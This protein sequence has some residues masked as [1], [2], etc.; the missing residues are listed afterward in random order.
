VANLIGVVQSGYFLWG[1]ALG[2]LGLV[3]TW[4]VLARR[5]G[6]GPFAVG[7]AMVAVATVAAVG[8]SGEQT[9]AMW[10]GLGLIL[11]GTAAAGALGLSHPSIAASSIPGSIV[12]ALAAPANPAWVR[13]L[14]VFA[15]PLLGYFV[16]DFESRYADRGLGIVF[17]GLATMGTFLAVPDT[18]LVRALFAVC[19]PMSLT[20]WPRPLLW[21]GRSGAFLAVSIFVVFT[22]VGGIGRPASIV[23]ALACLGYL[24]LEPIAVRARP[25]LLDLP[26]VLHR[27]PEAMLMAAVPQLAIVLIASRLAA[28]LESVAGAAGVVIV[29]G[30]LAY[31]LLAW[32]ERTRLLDSAEAS[33]DV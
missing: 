33:S 31:L 11:V 18:E 17:F 19:L 10:S 23:G 28:P 20:G 32:A 27:T 25:A 7:G 4:L 24:V 21:M 16:V 15:I 9:T 22:A 26:T 12:V 30:A 13:L 2:C 3:L 8:I 14:V 5:T 6:V 1:I 29:V